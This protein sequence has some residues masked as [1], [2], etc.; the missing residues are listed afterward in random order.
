MGTNI[1]DIAV[2]AV[3]NASGSAGRLASSIRALEGIGKSLE[4]EIPWGRNTFS[5][6]YSLSKPCCDEKCRVEIYHTASASQDTL[7]GSL[8]SV[9]AERLHV[10]IHG[11]LPQVCSLPMYRHDE[12]FIFIDDSAACGISAADLPAYLLQLQCLLAC[13]I[14][15]RHDRTDAK[16]YSLVLLPSGAEASCHQPGNPE[17]RS[18]YISLR[19]KLLARGY[20]FLMKLK[21]KDSVY[22]CNY[23]N[24]KHGVALDEWSAQQKSLGSYR[25]LERCIP[26][27]SLYRLKTLQ[28][29]PIKDACR[30]LIRFKKGIYI[31]DMPAYCEGNIKLMG[32]IGLIVN[33]LIADDTSL[34]CETVSD[35]VKFYESVVREQYP[36]VEDTWLQGID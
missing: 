9:V 20:L 23:I 12:D 15:D 3:L 34:L 31:L 33:E 24:Q 7:G 2:K 10:N 16:D 5:W 28:M 26:Q 21:E 36:S 1:R 14:A 30:F 13:R 25:L 18:E 35:A 27:Y 6:K 29:D 8:F 32:V 11:H 17:L 4:P 19:E 22:V